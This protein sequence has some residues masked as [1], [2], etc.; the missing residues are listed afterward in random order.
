M[1][2]N[3]ANAYPTPVVCRD[4]IVVI[5]A[6]LGSWNHCGCNRES[7]YLH[8]LG[9]NAHL[10]IRCNLQFLFESLALGQFTPLNLLN[11]LFEELNPQISRTQLIDQAIVNKT[12][13]NTSLND[14]VPSYGLM[15]NQGHNQPSRLRIGF[16]KLLWQNIS[17]GEFKTFLG[18]VLVAARRAGHP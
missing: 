9:Q 4:H 8:V 11:Y 2:S 7:V 13:W 14:R 5:A 6:N 16:Q 17:N 3:V 15:P 12:F 18:Q 10:N 1:P